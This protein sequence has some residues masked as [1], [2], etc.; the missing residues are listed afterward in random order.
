MR[1]LKRSAI[2][3]LD[4]QLLDVWVVVIARKQMQLGSL[5]MVIPNLFICEEKSVQIYQVYL[6]FLLKH[7]RFDDVIHT[8]RTIRRFSVADKKQAWECAQ[9]TFKAE[10]VSLCERGEY[11]IAWN[12]LRR[13]ERQ[14]WG[15]PL[16]LRTQI[17]NTAEHLDMLLFGYV[18]ILYFLHKYKFGKQLLECA[19]ELLFDLGWD[20]EE[21]V[22][23]VYKSD[24]MV[25]RIQDVTLY[26]YCNATGFSLTEWS[27]WRRLVS[28]FDDMTISAAK[29]R[30]SSLLCDWNGIASVVQAIEM[31][32]QNMKARNRQALVHRY[33]KQRMGSLWT[34]ATKYFPEIAE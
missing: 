24:K 27:G 29:V 20:S 30:R 33:G 11:H 17:W 16:N 10:I 22:A 32:R 28:G 15:K 2:K 18:P 3:S 19:L 12:Q 13:M 4:A 14:I 26:H 8:A 5:A 9:F 7:R 21:I 6:A 34:S 1:F 25:S 31:K 23:Y